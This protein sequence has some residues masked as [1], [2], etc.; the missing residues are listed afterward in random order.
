[1]KPNVSRTKILNMP[2]VAVQS[3]LNTAFAYL[4][5]QCKI[6][7]MSRS[8]SSS[9][10]LYGSLIDLVGCSHSSGS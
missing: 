9:V 4:V 7:A 6:V 1:M 2:R 3:M 5:P 10:K 8:C